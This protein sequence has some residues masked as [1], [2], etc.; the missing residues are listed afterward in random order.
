VTYTDQGKRGRP[1]GPRS[2][3]RRSMATDARRRWHVAFKWYDLW[4]GFYW[5]RLGRT[6]YICPLP[7]VVFWRTFDGD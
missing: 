3:R 6:L 4:V 1:H 7:C 2:G 5:S